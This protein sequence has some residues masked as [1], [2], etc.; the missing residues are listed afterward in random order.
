MSEA[1]RDLNGVFTAPVSALTY[2]DIAVVLAAAK[3]SRIP[4]ALEI[5]HEKQQVIVLTVQ[6]RDEMLVAARTEG[7]A[8]RDNQIRHE[9]QQRFEAEAAKVVTAIAAFHRERQNYF[10]RVEAEVVKLALAITAKIL[11]REAQVDPMLLAALVSV[12]VNQLHD[13]SKVS[14]RIRP[15]D[16]AK[17][18]QYFASTP[19]GATVEIVED[20][21]LGVKDCILET[22]LGSANF[23]IDGQLKEVEQGFFDLLALRS[24]K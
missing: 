17:W 22:D 20:P 16:A 6:E 19:N 3:E 23:S 10:A 12:A 21:H 11:H 15:G 9:Y 24:D 4:T 8:E 5:E 1:P 7:A 2:T 18:R 14:V 13:G